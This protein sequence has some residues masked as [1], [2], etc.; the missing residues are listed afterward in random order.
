M[1][2]QLLFVYIFV[3]YSCQ[4]PQCP[5][6]G[7]NETEIFFPAE[8]CEQF[9]ECSGGVAY[10]FNCSDGLYFNIDTNQCDWETGL[11]LNPYYPSRSSMIEVFLEYPSRLL[12]PGFSLANSVR[13]PSPPHILENP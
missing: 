9:Y 7:D 3:A 1:F 11:Y 12:L 8:T 4:D 13:P 6:G 5:P 2:L 10:L